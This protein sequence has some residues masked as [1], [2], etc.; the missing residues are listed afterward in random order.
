MRA[1]TLPELPLL[2]LAYFYLKKLHPSNF[3]SGAGRAS[4][5]IYSGLARV[6]NVI[7]ATVGKRVGCSIKYGGYG[8]VRICKIRPVQ[9][10]GLDW[11]LTSP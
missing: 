8:R 3:P 11:Q 7:C 9:D 10:S 5:S 6:R 4:V 1:C 2:T